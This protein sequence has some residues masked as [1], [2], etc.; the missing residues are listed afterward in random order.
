MKNGKNICKQLKK[1]RK[2]IAESNDIPLEQPECTYKGEC[3][4][5]C[6][7]CDA[8]VRYLEQELSR[9]GKLGA[10]IVAASLTL[11]ACEPSGKMIEG[12][13]EYQGDAIESIDSV[14]TVQRR[15]T[16]STADK[17]DKPVLTDMDLPDVII[18]EGICI[19]N[20][21]DIDTFPEPGEEE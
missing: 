10:A 19:P 2:D 12:D 11:A 6:P 13:V 15:D 8:E 21:T 17:T 14:D 5:T 16:N 18:T 3:Q 20:E 9:K 4:G 7:R 1:I